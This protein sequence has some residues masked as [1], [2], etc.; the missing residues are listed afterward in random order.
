MQTVSATVSRRITCTFA[1]DM[2]LLC[3]L[4]PCPEPG[5][6]ATLSQRRSKHLSAKVTKAASL[7]CDS[8]KLVLLWACPADAP[9]TTLTCLSQ[10]MRQADGRHLC[11]TGA[12]FD[13][14]SSLHSLSTRCA[15][16]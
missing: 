6:A 5:A 3:W 8:R 10:G 2:P 12:A 15:Q 9:C 16:S 4:P 11:L 1:A 7:S 14:S 13:A